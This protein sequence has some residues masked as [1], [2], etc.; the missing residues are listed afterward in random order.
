M[1]SLVLAGCQLQRGVVVDVSD[2]VYVSVEALDD[3]V[4]ACDVLRTSTA[5]PPAYAPGDDVVLLAND[6]DAGYVLG[7]VDAPRP[8]SKPDVV[9]EPSDER[10]LTLRAHERI[11]IRCGDSALILRSDG[12]VVL[13]GRQVLTRARGVNKIKGAAVQIN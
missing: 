7:V 8:A 11:E 6:V 9:D 12:H 5:P 1:E 10:T 4:V 3:A 2:C 13:K